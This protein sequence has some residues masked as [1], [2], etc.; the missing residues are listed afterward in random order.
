V[1]GCPIRP[2]LDLLG[3]QLISTRSQQRTTPI[4][5]VVAAVDSATADV[6]R[7]FRDEGSRRAESGGGYLQGISDGR[8]SPDNPTDPGGDGGGE[9]TSPD[10]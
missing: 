1:T 7:A 3:H 5:M 4:V 10:P 2:R 6:M 8:I 9:P